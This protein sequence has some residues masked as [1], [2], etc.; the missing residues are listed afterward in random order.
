MLEMSFLRVPSCDMA[1]IRGQ[2]LGPVIAIRRNLKNTQF[3]LGR[4]PTLTA[5][6]AANWVQ[7]VS[8]WCGSGPS[9]SFL[10][11]DLGGD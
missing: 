11:H 4:F 5:T 1:R 7:A 3:G 8:V 2:R 9:Q 10:E 6:Q